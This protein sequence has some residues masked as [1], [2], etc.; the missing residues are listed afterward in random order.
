MLTVPVLVALVLFPE[1]RTVTVPLPMPELPPVTSSQADVLVAL[2]MQLAP[3]L[4][5]TCID[6]PV[7]AAVRVSG[8]IVKV[9]APG[10]GCVMV[11][12]WPA[13]VSVVLR[14]VLP[15][16]RRDGQRHAAV[17]AAAAAARDGDPRRAV[18]RRPGAAWPAVTLTVV[19]FA[20]ATPPSC[21]PG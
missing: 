9:Q 14:C 8:E 17:A 3:A 20:A 4:T 15:V 5:A 21:S 7:A 18:G 10:A 19:G 11:K 1:A 6:S 16:L 13:I 12:A 2:Q